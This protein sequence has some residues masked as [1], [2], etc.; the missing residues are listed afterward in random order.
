M[1]YSHSE[2]EVGIS[3]EG[4]NSREVGV[5]GSWWR[6]PGGGRTW[7]GGCGVSWNYFVFL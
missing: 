3:Q 7:N 6:H 2:N 1:G 5:A 4:R